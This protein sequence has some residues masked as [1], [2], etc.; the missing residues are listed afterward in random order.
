MNPI[1]LI[2]KSLRLNEEHLKLLVEDVPDSQMSIIPSKG[3]ENHPAWTIGHLYDA[4]EM[5]CEILGDKNTTP[6][7]WIKVFRRTGPGDPRTPQ[8]DETLYPTKEALL[9][10]YLESHK[11]QID[12]LND[13]SEEFLQEKMNWSFDTVF[14]TKL[15]VIHFMAAWHETNH[16]SQLTVWR[17]AMDLPGCLKPLKLKFKAGLL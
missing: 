13:R 8:A 6:E 14:P 9:K 17:R 16:I 3:I 11:R 7:A 10:K 12:L 1:E 2:K 4:S 5:S 15:E